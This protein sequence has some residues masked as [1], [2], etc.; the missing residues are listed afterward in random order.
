MARVT[1]DPPLPTARAVLSVRQWI[2]YATVAAITW[3]GGCRS[4]YGSLPTGPYLGH[5][6]LGHP[7]LGHPHLGH[8]HLGHPHLGHP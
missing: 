4:A 2:P 7:H 1:L 3:R 6:H 8:P 5:P